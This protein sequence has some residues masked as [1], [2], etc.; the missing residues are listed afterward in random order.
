MENIIREWS[1]P[2]IFIWCWRYERLKLCLLH[3]MPLQCAE[4]ESVVS[5]CLSLRNLGYFMKSCLENHYLVFSTIIALLFFNFSWNLL[6][7]RWTELFYLPKYF[8]TVLS[9]K[10]SYDFSIYYKK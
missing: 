1:W 7:T 8:D 6:C 3:H 9:N 5:H 10:I 4:G 2:L